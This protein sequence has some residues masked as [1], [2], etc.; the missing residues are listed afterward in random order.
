MNPYTKL[1]FNYI[2]IYLN[3]PQTYG[4]QTTPSV[5]TQA[6]AWGLQAQVDF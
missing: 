6:N 4:D 5:K 1:S 2:P 3:S